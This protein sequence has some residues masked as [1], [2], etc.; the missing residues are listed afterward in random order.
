MVLTAR[1]PLL[2]VLIFLEQKQ[3][4]VKKKK[5]KEPVT[6]RAKLRI[7]TCKKHCTAGLQNYETGR[8]FT[9]LVIYHGSKD[10]LVK[11]KQKS[12]KI[13]MLG[14]LRALLPIEQDHFLPQH[15]LV[16][17]LDGNEELLFFGTCDPSE[18][19]LEP[20][21]DMDNIALLTLFI[22]LSNGFLSFRHTVGIHGLY[23]RSLLRHNNAVF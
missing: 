11:E 13:S 1:I 5:I 9:T 6:V 3:H 7:I 4:R 15:I 12:G 23:V 20:F 10:L 2:V 16:I 19:V 18:P 21:L 22:C 8:D 17:N 14:P